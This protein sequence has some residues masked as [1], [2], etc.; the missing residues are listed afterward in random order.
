MKIRHQTIKARPIKT[1]V[2]RCPK[3]NNS[4]QT[5]WWELGSSPD[6]TAVLP[7]MLDDENRMR[8][9]KYWRAAEDRG[10]Y[11]GFGWKRPGPHVRYIVYEAAAFALC[12]TDRYLCIYDVSSLARA[13][14]L[15]RKLGP[16]TVVMQ[17]REVYRTFW[18][19]PSNPHVRASGLRRWDDRRWWIMTDRGLVPCLGPERQRIEADD[20]Q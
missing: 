6:S 16:G 8:T 12:V 3:F 17:V 15:A 11:K 19:D 10:Y 18:R 4:I 7:R 20:E 1:E 9:E 5:R 13:Q 14:W 2:L